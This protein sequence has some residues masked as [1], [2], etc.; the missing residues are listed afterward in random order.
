[1]ENYSFFSAYGKVIIS[2]AFLPEVMKTITSRNVGGI[3][4]G[5]K[6]ICQVRKE[7]RELWGAVC[8]GGPVRESWMWKRPHG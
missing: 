6:Y 8:G 7:M 4:G 1:L 5:A 3:A 2:E